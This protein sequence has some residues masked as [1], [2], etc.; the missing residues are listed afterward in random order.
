MAPDSAVISSPD[1][2]AKSGIS[3]QL[4]ANL[5]AHVR[6][7]LT[8]EQRAA[9]VEAARHCKWG[10]HP[11]DIRL[12]IP[13]FSKRYYLVLLAGEERR[14]RARVTAERANHPFATSGN[15]LFVGAVVTLATILGSLLWTVGFVWY[16]ST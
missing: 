6:D 15:V 4:L 8:A 1:A 5:P 12:S 7:S 2:E 13:L 16:L 9:L 11:T 3:R 14:N 10:Q